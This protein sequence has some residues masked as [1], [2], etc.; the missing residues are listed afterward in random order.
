M[1]RIE[2]PPTRN[3]SSGATSAGTTTLSTIPEPNTAWGPSATN[4]E[5]TTP[6][7]SA[8]DD[9]EGRPKYHV[10]RF[11]AIA[12]TSPANTIAGVISSAST[13][14]EATVAATSSD[15]NAPTKFSTAARPAATR[16][17]SARVEIDV[18]TALAV[19]WKPLV[20]SNASAVATTI[21][22]TTSVSM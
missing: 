4:A 2:R 1:T 17:F 15:R 16:G 22:R 14:P 11:Q 20:K 5:P 18:A 12:P 19:S 10:A 21:T 9:D 6:P 3:A 13:I 7:I 8:C